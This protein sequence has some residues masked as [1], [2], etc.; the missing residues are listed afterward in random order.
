MAIERPTFSES[1]YRVAALSP[2][3]RSTVQVIRQHFRGQMWHVVHDPS[4]NQFFRLNE[5]AYAFVA[6]LDGRRK[7][8]EVWRICNEQ[9]G[10]AAPTQ[11][12]AIQLLGQLYTSNLI[13]GDLPP[14]AEGLLNRY[15]KRVHREVTSY[16]KNFLFIRIPLIDPDR[17]LDAVLPMVRWMWSGVG[18]AM[19]AALAT[20]GLYFI[21]G[22]FGKLVNQGKDIFSRKE[23]MANLMG[24]YGSFILVK[25]I[26]EF[27]HAFACKK[28][29]RQGGTGGEVHVMGVMFLVFTPLPYMDASSAWAFRNKWHRVIVGMG[30]MLVELAIASTAAIVWHFVPSGPVN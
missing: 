11:G 8:S 5:A 6:M 20:V 9:L 2:R 29:G 28:F 16:L 21:I 26:H 7:V 3:L 24:M 10:D 27:G 17:F 25:V 14:D 12:E 23:L 15:R 22:D 19:L 18:L 1:W 13:H 4:N 30:G